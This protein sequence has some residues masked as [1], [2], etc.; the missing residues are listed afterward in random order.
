[1]E[2]CSDLQISN[3]IKVT[4]YRNSLTSDIV[5]LEFEK[6]GTIRKYSETDEYLSIT[7]EKKEGM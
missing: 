2:S 7:F 6:H 3:T 5:I 4:G 1:M